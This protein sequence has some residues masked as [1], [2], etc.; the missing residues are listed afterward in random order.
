MWPVLASVDNSTWTLASLARM[1]RE[2]SMS[3]FSL[4]PTQLPLSMPSYLTPSLLPGMSELN[5]ALKEPFEDH[6]KI[7][8]RKS[9]VSYKIPEII[10]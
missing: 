2:E 9:G 5:L 3:A 10:S 1:L 7:S 8:V 6:L 4:R